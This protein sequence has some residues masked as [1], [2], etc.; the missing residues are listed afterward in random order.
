MDSTENDIT[1]IDV[2]S[3]IRRRHRVLLT[4]AL[5]IFSVGLVIAITLP[6]IYESSA[7]ILIEKQEIPSDLVRS[8]VTSFADQ[9]IQVIG[10]RVMSSRN[11][12]SIIDKYDLYRD[13]RSREPMEEVL[14]RMRADISREMISADVVD[15][16]SG[17]PTEATIAFSVAFEYRN[18]QK[19]QQVANELVSLFL[20]ENIKSRAESA[21]ETTSFLD[22]E[23][24]DIRTTV[25]GFEGEI[26]AFKDRHLQSRPELEGITRDMMNRTELRL[27]EVDRRV[28]ETIQQKIYLEAELARYDPVLPDEGP[29]GTTA[30]SQLRAV[31]AQL[32]AAEASYGALHPDVIRLKKQAEAMRATVEPNETR[33]LYSQQLTVSRMNLGNLSE[34]YGQRHPDVVRARKEVEKLENKLA[35]LPPVMEQV[36]NNPAFVALAARLEAADAQLIS[37]NTSREGLVQKIEEYAESLISIPDAESEYRA[38]N[39]EYETALAKYREI[40]TK[41]TQARLSQNLETERKGEKFTL[42]E[43]PLLPAQ[44]TKPNRIAI[45]L[46]S[47]MASIAG[48]LGVIGVAEAVDDRIRGRKGLR[49]VMDAPPLA[50][51]PIIEFESGRST[52]RSYAIVAAVTLALF[53]LGLVFIE[54]LVMPLDVA[55]FTLLRKL[56]I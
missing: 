34:S 38:L 30:L 42:I 16:R 43:P 48:G 20:N 27:S 46:V 53:V 19:A 23:V 51:I 50:V 10:Q 11:L 47:L 36:P 28:H 24:E 54:F 49:E 3:T 33:A 31:E 8:T 32:T 35:A 22:N 12:G 39:R 25:Q 26:A 21:A 41:Q 5:G 7:I 14:E 56:G 52:F 15:P 40:V 18:P 45:A 2:V 9:R 6:S 1:L 37:L 4:V 55:W 13:A 29:R 17:R 44:P